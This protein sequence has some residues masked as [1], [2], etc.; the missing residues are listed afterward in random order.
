MTKLT[1]TQAILLTTAAAR[2]HGMLLPAPNTIT[3]PADRIRKA[4]I[5]LITCGMAVEIDVTDANLALRSDGDNH[6]GAAITEAGR[7]A[8]GVTEGDEEITPP[9]QPDAA[10]PKRETKSGAVISLLQRGEGATL[11]ELIA[12]TDW[13]PHTTRAALTGIRKKGHT[14]EKSRRGEEACYRIVA[15]G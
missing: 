11:A 9:I 15:A 1:D 8:I 3:A 10:A 4:V 13:L 7:A 14:I 6:V 2:D 5:S 12:A